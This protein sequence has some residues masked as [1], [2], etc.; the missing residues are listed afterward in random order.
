M[1]R[2]GFRLTYPLPPLLSGGALVVLP[3]LRFYTPLIEPGLQVS[4]TRHSDKTSR[5]HPRLLATLALSPIRDTLIEGFS[6]FVTSM[7]AAIASGWSEFAGWGLH[8]LE[9]A[10]FARR[11][12]KT[13]ISV[14]R[15]RFLLLGDKRGIGGTTCPRLSCGLSHQRV[16]AARGQLQKLPASRAAYAIGS[17]FRKRAPSQSSSG[18]I[19]IVETRLGYLFHRRQHRSI[20]N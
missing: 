5:L 18:I 10:A 8:P 17:W 16:S 14:L 4:R 9:S 19:Q 2:G 1:W 3:W 12:P 13:D 11:T 7:T 15:R 20:A 6:H